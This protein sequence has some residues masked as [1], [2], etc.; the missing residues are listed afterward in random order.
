[1]KLKKSGGFTL[2]EIMIVVLIIA[3]L[4][5]I[6]VPGFLK[7]REE[8]RRS[9]CLNNLRLIDHAK[10]ECA[11]SENLATGAAV[12]NYTLYLKDNSV[13]ECPAGGNYTINVLGTKPACSANGHAN[14]Y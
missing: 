13:P 8:S 1:M 2:V 7:M 3:L 10:E 14:I 5:T 4:A 9:A 11:M 12:G 6:A